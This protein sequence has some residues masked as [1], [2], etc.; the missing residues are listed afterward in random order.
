MS[1]S[2]VVKTYLAAHSKKRIT[3]R[4][5]NQAKPQGAS[6]RELVLEASRR[7]N[8]DLLHDV[9]ASIAKEFGKKEAPAEIA[10]LL[11]HARDGIGAGVLHIAA[12][13]GNYEVL[14]LLLD[15]EGLEIE[16]LDRLEGDTPLHKA[17]RFVNGCEKGEW[18]GAAPV[19][20]ILLDAGADPRVRNKAK[21][22]PVELADPRN[23]GL[24]MMLQKAEYSLTV[25]DDVVDEDEEDDGGPPSDDE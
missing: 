25:G 9:F 10:S 1:D 22:K 16:G 24:K 21:L 23:D 17:V 7:N 4:D 12:A 15:Q 20:E 19:V 11:N 14:D 2:E 6:P 13:N 5:A 8:T 3:A 18:E